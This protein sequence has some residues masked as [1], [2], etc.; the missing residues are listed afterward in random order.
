VPVV[1]KAP[2]ISKY[3]GPDDSVDAKLS[4]IEQWTELH[5]EDQ[6]SLHQIAVDNRAIIDSNSNRITKLE[7]QYLNVAETITAFTWWFRAVAMMIATQLLVGAYEFAKSI[8]E[9]QKK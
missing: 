1:I 8:I 4:R 3:R 9:R 2:A 5:S 6:R 7:I